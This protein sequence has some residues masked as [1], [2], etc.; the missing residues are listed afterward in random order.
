MAGNTTNQNI[1]VLSNHTY[2][3]LNLI[4]IIEEPHYQAKF[5]LEKLQENAL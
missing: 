3:Q 5:A 2:S 1:L 4:L